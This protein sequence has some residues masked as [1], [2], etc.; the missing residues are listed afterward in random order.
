MR[1]PAKVSTCNNKRMPTSFHTLLSNL[2]DTIRTK[3]GNKHGRQRHVEIVLTVKFQQYLSTPRNRKKYLQFE[4]QNKKKGDVT[5]A[6]LPSSKCLRPMLATRL[7]LY[8]GTKPGGGV[9][10]AEEKY[11][12]GDKDV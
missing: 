12:E 4:S 10:V 1:L 11:N 5:P 2:T 9:V 3:K 7:R 8:S 6:H